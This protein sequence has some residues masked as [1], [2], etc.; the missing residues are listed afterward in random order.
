MT[1]RITTFFEE[2]LLPA[3]ECRNSRLG[4]EV[5]KTDIYLIGVIAYILLTGRPPFYGKSNF[6]VVNKIIRGKVS[7]PSKSKLSVCCKEFVKL[8]LNKDTSKR[9]SAKDA[10]EHRWLNGGQ[11]TEKLEI[12]YLKYISNYSK[13][14]KLKKV[15]VRM[16]T[17]DMEECAYQTLKEQFDKMDTDG[18]G[19]IDLEELT[20]VIYK[21]GVIR[22]EAEA[23]AT[24]IIAELDEDG[25][26]KVNMDEWTN[27]K[28]AGKLG[29][30]EK[31]RVTFEAIDYDGDGYITHDELVKYFDGLLAKEHIAEMIKEVDEN[32]DDRISYE[33]FAKTMKHG[34]IERTLADL[35]PQNSDQ[36]L[37][38]GGQEVSG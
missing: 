17:N 8:L 24:A 29:R 31:I 38:R 19:Q 36:P 2:L 34:D 18:N 6:E 37:K 11:A 21:Q 5:K 12:N 16:I 14:S 4:W 33:E 20:E 3:P 35:F 27:A 23:R 13:A 30:D 1:K 28:V 25:D 26:G 32:N 9:L 22:T 7:F 15:V 10:L